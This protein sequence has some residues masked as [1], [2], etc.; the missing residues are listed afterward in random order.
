MEVIN[1]HIAA[2]REML[3]CLGQHKDCPELREEIRKLRS[4]LV[5]EFQITAHIL[6]SLN[7]EEN[8]EN[9]NQYLI[10]IFHLLQLFLSELTKSYRLTE[11]IH[12][13]MKEYFGN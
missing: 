3:I 10:L 4:N 11:I 7:K 6:I 1:H 9:E 2:F 8:V 12:I 5:E 13:D